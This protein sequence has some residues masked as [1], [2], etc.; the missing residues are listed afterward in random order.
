MHIREE[1]RVVE[2]ASAFSSGDTVYLYAYA[3]ARVFLY[4]NK[5]KYIFYVYTPCTF[6]RLHS[7]ESLNIHNIHNIHIISKYTVYNTSLRACTICIYGGVYNAYTRV[8]NTYE[9]VCFSVIHRLQ[10]RST[11]QYILRVSYVTR[12]HACISASSTA[13]IPCKIAAPCRPSISTSSTGITRGKSTITTDV[14]E[15]GEE[16]EEE[17]AAAAAAAVETW[18]TRCMCQGRLC[19]WC[20]RLT[21]FLPD[22]VI[23]TRSGRLPW[24][25]E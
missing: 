20:A 9:R 16:K 24:G 5:I 4:T 11:L 14:G 8:C 17:E 19:M 12:I 3:F 15:E 1:A 23:P 21:F 13:W 10:D 2:L 7:Q 22:L 25:T 6:T 18:Q